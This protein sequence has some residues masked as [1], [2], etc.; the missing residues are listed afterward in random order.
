MPARI[1]GEPGWWIGLRRGP[2]PILKPAGC[3]E[4]KGLAVSEFGLRVWSWGLATATR[5]AAPASCGLRVKCKRN[6]G[7]CPISMGQRLTRFQV[8][9]IGTEPSP[10][11]IP[12]PRRIPCDLLPL[13]SCPAISGAASLSKT[14]PEDWRKTLLLPLPQP[15]DRV[16]TLHQPVPSHIAKSGSCSP[17][18]I[19][20]HVFQHGIESVER[21]KG[22]PF[23][24]NS[25]THR[26]LP[27]SLVWQLTSQLLTLLASTDQVID[28][29][30]HF[31]SRILP[32]ARSAF[33]P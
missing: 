31:N 17:P 20:L 3:A 24:A 23:S 5:W 33:A 6:R 19:D 12:R 22:K 2:K 27:R 4:R 29:I 8:H 13:A 1:E 32:S 26:S 15:L 30:L 7:S 9:S 16:A 25:S 10:G 28:P 11:S 21:Y 14:I 18:G